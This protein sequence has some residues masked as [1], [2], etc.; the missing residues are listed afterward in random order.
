MDRDLTY[1]KKRAEMDSVAYAYILSALSD[2]GNAPD[3]D[4]GRLVSGI[5]KLLPDAAVYSIDAS[6]YGALDPLRIS[7]AR[8]LSPDRWETSMSGVISCLDASGDALSGSSAEGGDSGSITGLEFGGYR[9]VVSFALTAASYIMYSI[10]IDRI[11]TEVEF[12]RSV[13]AETVS[14]FA[15][16]PFTDM[17]TLTDFIR[18]RGITNSRRLTVGGYRTGVVIARRVVESGILCGDGSVDDMSA[19]WRTLSDAGR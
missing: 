16:R 7:Y 9:N 11:P 12:S 6:G 14:T 15:V 4:F 3:T 8:D 2:S 19:K 13:T 17:G 18:G 5:R 10:R 1:D